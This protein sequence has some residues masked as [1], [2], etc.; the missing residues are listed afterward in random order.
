MRALGTKSIIHN[1]GDTTLEFP[2]TAAYIKRFR[3]LNPQTPVLTAK[4]KDQDFQNLCEIIGPPSRVMRWCCTVFKTG[5]ITKKIETT[6][7]GK[8]RIIS[9][10]GIRR[11]ESK[12]RSKYDRVTNNSKITKQL[13][14]SPIIDWIDFDVW[15]YILANN[16][17]FNAAYMQGFSRVGCWCC[18]NN[19]TWSAYLSGIYMNDEY[20]KW[21]DLLYRFARKVGKPDWKEYIDSGNW[22]ARQGGN[23]LEASKNIVV[24]FTPCAL[25]ENAYNFDLKKPI[26]ETLYT[27]FLPFGT[28][29]KTIGN[30][31]LNEVYYLDRKTGEPIL[32]LSGRIGSSKLKISV[33]KKIKQFKSTTIT[34]SL[35][36]AQ[37]TK[38]QTCMACSACQSVCRFDA[39]KVNN[40]SKGDVQPGDITY[41]IDA[42]KCVGCLE[43]VGHFD[44]GCYMYKVLKAKTGK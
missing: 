4:N 28:M 13:V 30:P 8:S 15:L 19:S 36:K 40:P 38:F 44:C 39:I 3:E 26:D 35:L 17:E 22:K 21:M 11:H 32:K 43:C 6:F 20:N 37:I 2:T 9:F 12:S 25:E 24:S 42:T 1:Y 31:R 27:Y 18:P 34:E 14:L 33:L 23:G 41:S 29:D 5:A 7:K 16:L 10:Q